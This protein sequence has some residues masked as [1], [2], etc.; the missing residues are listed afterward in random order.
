MK[1]KLMIILLVTT[2]VI[3]G[4]SSSNESEESETNT[5]E[6]FTDSTEEVSSSEEK[7]YTNDFNSDTNQM[8]SYFELEFEVPAEWEEDESSGD[9]FT[10]DFINGRFIVGSSEN[11]APGYDMSSEELQTGFLSSLEE[12]ATFSETGRDLITVL[13]GVPAL[14]ITATRD[15]SNGRMDM[16]YVAIAT[17]ERLYEF[18]CG[19]YQDSEYNHSED[20]E[21]VINSI[22]WSGGSVAEWEN[23]E[24]VKHIASYRYDGIEEDPDT[25]DPLIFWTVDFD[26][27]CDTNYYDYEDFKY[28]IE[29][30]L[31]QNESKENQYEG[32]GITAYD[33]DGNVCF[34]WMSYSDPDTITQFDWR[35]VTNESPNPNRYEWKITQEEINDLLS[36]GK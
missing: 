7:T 27:D 22:T 10:F 33:S 30:C 23:N 9:N 35:S 21:K 32:C 17:D 8:A 36:S 28:V 25:G 1:E 14:Y 11:P 4:C 29:A 3:A 26:D 6:E 15:Y 19:D 18:V 2:M 5:E 34:I 16:E 24:L 12:D 31:N 13:D 20:F